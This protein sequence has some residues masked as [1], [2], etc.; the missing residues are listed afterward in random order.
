[1]LRAVLED[2]F[3]LRI[4]EES[5]AVPVY[6]LIAASGGPK[7][8]TFV[9]G[10]CTDAPASFPSPQLPAGQRY[11]MARAGSRPPAID[12]EGASLDEFTKL[13]SLVLDRP[14][15]DKTGIAG[16]FTIHLEF[17]PDASTPRF[18]PGSELARFATA[19]A[20]GTPTIMRALEQLGLRL[21]LGSGNQRQLVIDH[22][23]KPTAE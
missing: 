15:I 18:L 2:R 1:M 14:V 16:R 6:T 19:P 3:K 8:N 17:A 21:E 4:R 20:A 5:A 22:I 7:L 12:A 11:C 9:D 10:S 23:E 13:L